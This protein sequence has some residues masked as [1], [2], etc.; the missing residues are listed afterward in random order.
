MALFFKSE[1]Q[2]T[3]DGLGAKRESFRGAAKAVSNGQRCQHAGREHLANGRRHRD[4][5]EC[6]KPV[7]GTG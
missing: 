3:P 2:R 4:L 1:E 5:A 6:R 7:C